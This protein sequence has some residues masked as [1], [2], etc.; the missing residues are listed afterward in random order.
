MIIIN[1]KL[2]Y[3]FLNNIIVYENDNVINILTIIIIK[4]EDVFTNFENI[5]N[6]SKK[7]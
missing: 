1:L 4:F 3:V 7:Q 2:K 6:F 5:I